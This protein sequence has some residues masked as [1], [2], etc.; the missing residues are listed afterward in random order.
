M[1]VRRRVDRSGRIGVSR[2]GYE[3]RVVGLAQNQRAC[4][5]IAR[6]V[7]P[8]VVTIDYRTSGETIAISGTHLLL[9]SPPAGGED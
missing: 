7:S 3:K 1:V 4:F 2:S 8:F 6:I 5:S 9:S